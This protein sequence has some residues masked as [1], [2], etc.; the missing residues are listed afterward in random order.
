MCMLMFN[1]LMVNMLNAVFAC[2]LS[3]SWNYVHFRCVCGLYIYIKKK[4]KSEFFDFELGL[5]TVN[6]SD[7]CFSTFVSADKGNFLVF[8]LGGAL[9]FTVTLVVLLSVSMYRSR[10]QS[11]GN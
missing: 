8:L 6:I 11:K 5:K 9:T 1:Y 7:P 10:G 2:L 4:D 3:V